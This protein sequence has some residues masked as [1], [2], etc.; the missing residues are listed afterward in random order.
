MNPGPGPKPESPP[1][2]NEGM[3]PGVFVVPIGLTLIL[4]PILLALKTL[5]GFLTSALRGSGSTGHALA[6]GLDWLILLTLVAVVALVFLVFALVTL[7]Y[8]NTRIQLTQQ[9]LRLKTGFLRRTESEV[10]VLHIESAVPR[11]PP[12]GRRLGYGTVTVVTR[13]G[14]SFTLA[15]LPHPER[16]RQA[17]L[18]LQSAPTELA[19]PH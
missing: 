9:H 10:E 2:Y 1:I 6:A 11:T 3:H 8:R 15:F 13:E 16:L 4:A 7:G 14:A 19:P 12:L 5:F 17:I 18:D